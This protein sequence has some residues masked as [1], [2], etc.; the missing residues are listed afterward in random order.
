MV[1]PRGESYTAPSG[2]V[3]AGGRILPPHHRVL[4]AIAAAPAESWVRLNAGMNALSSV[5]PPLDLRTRYGG[6]PAPFEPIQGCWPSI[7]WDSND[8]QLVLWG[9]G[10]ANTSANE[11]YVW[12]CEDRQWHL[13][14]LP[15]ANV[16]ATATPT[17][18][19]VDFGATPVS[20]HTYGNNNFLPKINRFFTGMGA[21][22]GDG[23]LVRLYDESNTF[24]RF[25]GAYTLDLS[26][27]RQNKLGGTTGSNVKVGDYVG[28]D[29]PGAQ[30]WKLRDWYR[31]GSSADIV[32]ASRTDNGTAYLEHNG[33][34]AVL[35]TG[36][37]RNV[38]LVEFPDDTGLNDVATRVG[39]Q[40]ASAVLGQGQLAYSPDHQVLL[41]TT[42]GANANMVEFLDLKRSWGVGNGWRQITLAS[43]AARDEF[44]ALNIRW[45]GLVYN[46]IKGCFTIWNMGSQVW[47]IY[48]PA[49]NPTPDTGWEVI[50]P[51]M[52]T[53]GT[54]PRSSYIL[55]GVNQETGTIG[56]FRWASDLN[57]AVATFGNQTGEVWA[58]KPAGWSQP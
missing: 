38:W 34:D 46:P 36:G 56:K 55:S 17:Y 30:A 33:N 52:D 47:E 28:V 50:K 57:A 53:S 20:S 22:H 44:V 13:A 11:V 2:A 48:P 9:G 54:Q 58:Y 23:G 27:A 25:A 31:A 5:A 8:H 51:T 21:A 12:R 40:G 35:I 29:L 39:S 15:S 19:S 45:C 14:F 42:N 41:G 6:S 37:N 4:A 26:Q 49:G 1:T 3:V 10:H 16:Q 7:G 18:R 24:L 43:G 32:S